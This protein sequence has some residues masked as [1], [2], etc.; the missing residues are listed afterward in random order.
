MKKQFNNKN[1]KLK[2]LTPKSCGHNTVPLH[3]FQRF[4]IILESADTI[5]YPHTHHCIPHWYIK[6]VHEFSLKITRN[7]QSLDEVMFCRKFLG[8]LCSPF[9]FSHPVE[10]Q[11]NKRGSTHKISNKTG[12]NNALDHLQRVV[13][14]VSLIWKEGPGLM[15]QHCSAIACAYNR[16]A[17]SLIL[18]VTI[19]HPK[20]IRI[21]NIYI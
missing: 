1:K 3:H 8:M 7:L 14:Q 12:E 9:F 17:Y 16:I 2:K 18:W 5:V 21:S 10:Q 4:T 11:N 19:V 15:N 20:R 6:N 13:Y